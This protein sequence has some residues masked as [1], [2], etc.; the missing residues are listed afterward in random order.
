MADLTTGLTSWWKFDTQNGFDASIHSHT[1]AFPNSVSYVTGK[2]GPYCT[3]YNG[4]SQYGKYTGVLITSGSFTI[5]MWV[6]LSSVS[7]ALLT[8]AQGPSNGSYIYLTMQSVLGGFAFCVNNSASKVS[9]GS[10]MPSINTWYHIVGTYNSS[11]GFTKIYQNGVGGGSNTSTANYGG[12]R[13]IVGAGAS[14]PGAFTN[15]N[16]DDVRIYNKELTASD[17]TA[18]Y[19]YTF[20][21][22]NILC[23]DFWLGQNFMPNAGYLPGTENTRMWGAGETNVKYNVF[24]SDSTMTRRPLQTEIV[25]RF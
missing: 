5:S 24:I 13:F 8:V 12:D 19:N 2:I 25:G 11:T 3:Q 22:T 4:T 21:P 6:N 17:V 1:L 10:T 23:T 18:L 15:G 7:T 16:I 9:F 20:N 14:G